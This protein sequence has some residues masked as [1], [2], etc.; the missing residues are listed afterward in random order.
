MS[1]I[2]ERLAA[3]QSVRFSPSGVSMLPMLR[4]GKDSV[5]LSPVAG[6]LKKYDLAL[7]RRDDG[8]YVLHRVVHADEFYTCIGDNQFTLEHGIR[9]DQ[10]IAVVTAFYRDD[11]M[12]RVEE[13]I[14]WLYCRLWH[15]SR[16]LRHFWQRARNWLRRHI[17][18]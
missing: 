9:Q 16:A 7:Y 15:S 8:K 3:G 18:R 13:P 10:L 6:R 4:Q 12:H 17:P 14:Y 5:V 11:K 1:L 2:R